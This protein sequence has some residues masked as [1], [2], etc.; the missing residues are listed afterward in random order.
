MM[1]LQPTISLNIWTADGVT[2]DPVPA[3]QHVTVNVGDH[4]R[5]FSTD[6]E[7]F[8]QVARAFWDAADHLRAKQGPDPEVARTLAMATGGGA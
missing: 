6:P 1:E 5:V 8:E 7:V 4:V 2:V 3:H